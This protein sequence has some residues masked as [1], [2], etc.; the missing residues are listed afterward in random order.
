[1][2]LLDASGSWRVLV[3]R[4]GLLGWADASHL[5]LND[6]INGLTGLDGSTR[7]WQEPCCHGTG[8][9]GPLSP[10][11]STIAGMTLNSDFVHYSVT[12]LNVA[13]GSSSTVL[14]VQDVRGCSAFSDGSSGRADCEA[15]HPETI[16]PDAMSGYARAA[17]WSPT[18][19]AVLV[20]D[21]R[22]DSAAGA[23]RIVK[24]DGS[25]AGPIVSVDLLDLSETLGFPNAAPRVIWL[26]GAGPQP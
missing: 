10:D 24:T 11:G 16:G 9:S 20:L 7:P 2:A 6:G 21:Q 12:L 13:D 5:V 23:V 15:A 18:G 25:G 19:D 17:A 8:F 14:T 3:A 26:P 4:A 1:V 22:P